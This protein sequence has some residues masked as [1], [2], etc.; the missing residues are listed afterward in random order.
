VGSIYSERERE[1]EKKERCKHYD[2]P[3]QDPDS[4]PEP[5]EFE[6]GNVPLRR[7]VRINIG[8]ALKSMIHNPKFWIDISRL[9]TPT[10][11]LKKKPVNYDAG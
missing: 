9:T 4:K 7:N 6:G 10:E 5:T 8:G 11:A 3:S 1:R 2:S